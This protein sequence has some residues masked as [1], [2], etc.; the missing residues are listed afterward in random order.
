MRINRVVYRLWHNKSVVGRVGYIGKDSYYP[1]RTKIFYRRKDKNSPKLYR[2]ICKYPISLWR[3]E[4]LAK[5]FQ[6]N[7][8]LCKAEIFWIKKFDSKNKGY[9]CTDGG[10]GQLGWKPSI[11]TR[12]KISK[13]AMGNKHLLG[14]RHSIEARERMSKAHKNPSAET[15]EK[16]S[17]SHIGNKNSEGHKNYLGHKHSPEAKAKMSKARKV[18]W[19]NR[20]EE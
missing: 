9:N 16:M 12:T 10:E 2:A 14:H 4:I 15:R 3:V 19:R 5:G 20:K 1:H 13:A 6:S 11:E 7:I 17:K 8:T 18:W